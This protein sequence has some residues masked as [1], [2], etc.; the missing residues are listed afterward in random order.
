MKRKLVS[1]LTEVALMIIDADGNQ[2]IVAESAIKISELLAIIEAQ[3]KELAKQKKHI[4]YLTVLKANPG[5]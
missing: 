4:E 2:V 3:E 5:Q 1:R